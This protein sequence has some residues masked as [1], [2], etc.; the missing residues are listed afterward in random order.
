M[1]VIQKIL[2]TADISEARGGVIEFE[3]NT[4]GTIHIQNNIWRL[5]MGGQEFLDFAVS[6]VEAGER[7]KKMKGLE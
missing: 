7:L 1:G 6:C 4:C 5:E 3:L 2:A